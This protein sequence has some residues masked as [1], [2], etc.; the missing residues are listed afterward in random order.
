MRLVVLELR[1]AWAD[2]VDHVLKAHLAGGGDS[3]AGTAGSNG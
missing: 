2:V 3:G 1:R